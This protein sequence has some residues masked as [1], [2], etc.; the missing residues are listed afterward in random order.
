MN[1]YLF[2]KGDGVKSFWD[3]CIST[4][5]VV[6]SFPLNKFTKAVE[7]TQRYSL[8]DKISRKHV[9]FSSVDDPSYLK[10]IQ[11]LDILGMTIMGFRLNDIKTF[12]GKITHHW[13]KTLVYASVMETANA[14]QQSVASNAAFYG[15]SEAGDIVNLVTDMV[16]PEGQIL[17][18]WFFAYKAK[19]DLYYIIPN[20]ENLNIGDVEPAS[21]EQN[22]V[23]VIGSHEGTFNDLFFKPSFS[24]NATVLNDNHIMVYDNELKITPF[25]NYN[26]KSLEGFFK[27]DHVKCSTNFDYTRD[28]KG[29]YFNVNKP[30]G[31]IILRYNTSTVMDVKLLRS[32][33][34]FKEYAVTKIER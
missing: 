1:L 27:V 6:P 15:R 31:Y 24:K 10:M 9:L 26:T 25:D 21:D 13:D 33:R 19:Y 12:M 2:Q 29:F 30:N 3:D 4:A 7:Y 32:N 17:V 18:P 11:P 16:L 23:K 34:F 5:S 14:T 22:L 20:P 8:Y 28:D